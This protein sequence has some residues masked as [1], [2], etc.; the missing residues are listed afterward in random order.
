[1]TD[2]RPVLSRA[3][4]DRAAIRRRDTDWLAASWGTAQVLAVDPDYT[5]PI[6][7]TDDGPVLLWRTA[8]TVDSSQ[9]YVF[10]G[11]HDGT[12]YAVVRSARDLHADRWLGLREIGAELPEVE[13]GLLVEAIALAQWHDRHLYCPRCGRETA[14]EQAGW[15][16]RCTQ[17][18]EQFPRTDP[19]VIMLVHDG[20]DRCILGRQAVWPAG[21]FSILAGFVEP[22]ESAEAAVA[23][24]VFEEVGVTVT[25]VRYAG[26]QPWPFPSSLMLGFTAQVSGDPTLHIDEHEIAEAHWLTRSEVAEQPAY[27]RLPPPLSIAHRIITDWVDGVLP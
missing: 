12:A 14:S 22:G 4:H 25:D 6:V 7:E 13:A 16:R 19:A 26:S 8:S 21:R 2:R 20:A 10:L 5:V 27:R 15:V 1:M 11:E 24:E 9:E 23:R 18:H 17:G 3:V